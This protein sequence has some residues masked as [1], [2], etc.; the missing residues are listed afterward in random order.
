L[1]RTPEQHPAAAAEGPLV[2]VVT[3]FLDAERFLS[4]AIESVLAQTH[5]D[6][7]LLLV[8]DGSTDGSTLI[9]RNCA[10]S[11]PDRIRYLDHPEH[12][13]RGMSASRNLGLRHARGR[14]LALLDADDRWLPTKLERQVAILER[15]TD[16]DMLYGKTLYWF[17]W[18]EDAVAEDAV[19]GHG[20]AGDRVWDPPVLLTLFLSGRAAVP[21]TCSLLVRREAA[22]KVA[23]FEEAF[24]GLY[25]DQVLYA[26]LCLEHRV[27]VS[28]ECLDWYR[29]HPDSA[30]AP[31]GSEA[32]R[33]ARY[34]FFRWLVGYVEARRVRDD[35]LAMTLRRESWRCR[36]T[37]A[38]FGRPLPV[39]AVRLARKWILRIESALPEVLRRRIWRDAVR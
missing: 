7:E 27:F 21:S 5:Q 17:G 29:Q 36:P 4:E 24:R 26:K 8:D 30:S 11:H 22:E 34:E 6:W 32:D 35:E 37:P 18:K 9:A 12:A 15:L 3:I 28:N 16:V 1:S 2:S 38:P 10:A 33:R 25:E 31:L 19:Q 23:G 13:N 14:Y 39:Q 20:I